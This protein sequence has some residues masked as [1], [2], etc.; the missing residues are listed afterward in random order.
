L[1]QTVRAKNPGLPVLC[2]G[3]SMGAN[4]SIRLAARNPKL[5]DGLILSSPCVVKRSVL[6]APRTVVD[7]LLFLMAPWRQL[8]L[9]PY[10]KLYA[11]DDPETLRNMMDDP[12]NRTKMSVCGLLRT[13]HMLK[14]SLAY[15]ASMRSDIPVMVVEGSKDHLCSFPPV[16]N[17]VARLKTKDKAM[18][19]ARHG[20]HLLL[21]TDNIEPEISATIDNWLQQKA[22]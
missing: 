2:M 9:E 17:L 4:M 8:N 5:V 21:E 18:Y 14:S 20:S 12:L 22:P 13:L 11:S 1:L 16:K 6:F 10:A 15:T 3:E 7:V 19:L